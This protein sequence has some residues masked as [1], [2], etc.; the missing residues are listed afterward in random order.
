MYLK[1]H[2]NDIH[3]LNK[4]VEIPS[5]PKI[6]IFKLLI[7]V[8]ASRFGFTEPTD[9]ENETR[10]QYMSLKADMYLLEFSLVCEAGLILSCSLSE[11]KETRPKAVL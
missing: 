5:F 11:E 2:R 4:R 7:H 1:K 6:H 9:L 10:L 8:F 3:V